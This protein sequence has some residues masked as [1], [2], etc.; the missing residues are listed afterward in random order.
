[1]V[2][3]WM[4]SPNH[5]DNILLATYTEIGVGVVVGSGKFGTYWAQEFGDA[6]ARGGA[7]VQN[8]PAD[9][10]SDASDDNGE[11]PPSP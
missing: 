4:A 2:A 8:A 5:R 7:D 9:A 1:V 3:G 11:T 6:Q 10:T